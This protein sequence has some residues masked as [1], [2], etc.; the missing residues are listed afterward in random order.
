MRKFEIGSEVILK[1]HNWVMRVAF[2]QE[3]GKVKCRW[4]ENG[5]PKTDDFDEDELEIFVKKEIPVYQK[6]QKPTLRKRNESSIF[7]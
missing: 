7:G 4:I 6:K 5:Q 3:D 1:S 2:Y